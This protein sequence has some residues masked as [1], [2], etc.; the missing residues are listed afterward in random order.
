MNNC[1][2]KKN[3]IKVQATEAR[4][5]ELKKAAAGSA[6]EEYLEGLLKQIESLNQASKD[7]ETNFKVKEKRFVVYS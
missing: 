1:R 4:F 7:V 3:K 6:G 5:G 2:L